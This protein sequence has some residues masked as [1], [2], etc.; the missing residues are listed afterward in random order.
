MTSTPRWSSRSSITSKPTAATAHGPAARLAA[1]RSLF[2]YAALCHPEH[3]EVIARVLAIPQKRFD[4]AIVSFLTAT[5]IDALLDAPDTGRWEGRRDRAL[6]ALAT[7]TGSGCPSSP[8]STAATSTS[9]PAPTFVASARAANSGPCPS[10]TAPWPCCGSGCRNAAVTPPA[11]PASFNPPTASPEL[12]APPTSESP[13][14]SEYIVQRHD[15]LWS[16][17][18]GVLGDGFR[19]R[20]IRDVNVGKLQPDGG[21]LTATS[22]VIH[23][24]W[25]LDVPLSTQSAPPPS[26]VPATHTVQPGEHLWEIAEGTLEAALS[27]EASDAEI[28]PYWREVVEQNRA[29]LPDPSNPSVLYSGHIVRL[30]AVPGAELE[31]DDGIQEPNPEPSE[32]PGDPA[33]A[34][35]PPSPPSDSALPAPRSSTPTSTPGDTPE[36]LGDPDS[37]IPIEDEADSED[38]VAAG[39]LG[40]AGTGLA[41]VVALLARRR[42]DRQARA[43]PGHVSPAMPNDLRDTHREVV[44]RADLDQRAEVRAALAE[45]AGHVAGRRRARCRPRLV[46]VNSTRIDVLLDEPD[47]NPPP[48][49]TVEAS[50]Q[51]WAAPRNNE[52]T[53]TDDVCVAPLL[54]TLGRPDGMTEILYDLEG[55]GTTTLTGDADA[56]L[57]LARSILYEIVH[58]PDEV[59]VVIVSDLPAPDDPRVRIAGSWDEIADDTL[60]WALLSIRSLHFRPTSSPPPFSPAAPDAAST[61]PS[62]SCSSSTP[63]PTTSGSTSYSTSRTEVLRLPWSSS[64][65]FARSERAWCST[66]R[67]WPSPP[68]AWS[69]RRRASIQRSQTTSTDFSKLLTGRHR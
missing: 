48:G 25:I 34:A 47:V 15:S 20:E 65:T 23:P 1:V 67:D 31:P 36:P 33:V 10:P 12:A 37:T 50:G 59:S 22:D 29:D 16:I 7:Q 19:W 32:S 26:P 9:T 57:R 68:S 40:V 13:A 64:R 38:G 52:L 2:R 30:P 55:A 21:T 42:R 54:V 41:A 53:D 35:S 3:A 58:Q 6:L 17:A 27:R 51:V 5:E 44:A 60:A 8:G 4:K 43:A 63:H 24:G 62:P 46:Q 61:A 66:A 28:D 49:W 69:S 14:T 45:V 18:E 39:V 56:A 11:S